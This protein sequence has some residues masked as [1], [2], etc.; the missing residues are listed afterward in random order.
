MGTK[1][2][3]RLA[4]VAW[5]ILL[6]YGL[7]GVVSGVSQFDRFIQRDYFQ[8]G[9]FREQLDQFVQ[10]LSMMELNDFSKKEIEKNIDVTKSDIQHY[11]YYYGGLDAQTDNI[12]KQY[13]DQIEK[14]KNDNNTELEKRYIAERDRKIKEITNNFLSDQVVKDKII[15]D[16][17]SRIEALK[18]SEKKRSQRELDSEKQVFKYYLTDTETGKVYTNLS[19][20]DPSTSDIGNKEKW[21]TA[22][23]EAADQS[24]LYTGDYIGGVS[25]DDVR[26][27]S[28]QFDSQNLSDLLMKS[29]KSFE[30]Q[31]IVPKAAPRNSFIMAS[32]RDF[33]TNQLVFYIFSGSALLALNC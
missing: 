11:R 23:Y 1:L 28:V 9:V 26:I 33:N 2:K 27:E 30:G 5:F 31:I 18:D 17:M 16:V 13:Q 32:Y 25:E 4:L 6:T 22:D 14:A 15:T 24:E 19:A 3:S 21:F 29:A 7:A 20:D 12:R 8:T 10:A